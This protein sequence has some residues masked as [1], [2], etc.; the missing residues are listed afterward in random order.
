MAAA[1]RRRRGAQPSG[2]FAGDGA[3]AEYPFYKNTIDRAANLC[4]WLPMESPDAPSF[5]TE[6]HFVPLDHP[7]P[8]CDVSGTLA[9]DLTGACEAECDSAGIRIWREH[10]WT[11]DRV[12]TFLNALADCGVVADA[13]RAAGMSRQSAYNLRNRTASRAFHLAWAAAELRARQRLS[14]ELM[15]RAIHGFVEVTLRTGGI[16]EE[17][18]RFDNRLGLAMLTRLDR[19]AEAK[20]SESRAV[21]IISKEF[22]QFLD[23]VCG[24]LDGSIAS[25]FLAVRRKDWDSYNTDRDCTLLH[26]A[27]NYRLCGAGVRAEMRVDDLD[28]DR[29]A[30]WTDEQWERARLAELVDEQAYGARPG[31]RDAN[32]ADGGA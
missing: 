30:E 28:L 19:K 6:P 27:H 25:D 24:T 4:Y 13:A 5:D 29:R 2:D 3:P 8:A 32:A 11:P 10:G 26:R 22:D 9:S 14:D 21:D 12:R 17:R 31:A 18:H 23:I 7:S 20:D 15:S 16:R 1:W